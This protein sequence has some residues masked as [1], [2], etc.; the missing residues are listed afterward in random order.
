MVS[1][2]PLDQR[3]FPVNMSMTWR[4]QD[5]VTE[6]VGI[7]GSSTARGT[8]LRGRVARGEGGETDSKEGQ[9]PRN[10]YSQP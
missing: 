9:R 5:E 6:R 3:V 2:V 4:S 7:V 1:E 10:Y 8:H